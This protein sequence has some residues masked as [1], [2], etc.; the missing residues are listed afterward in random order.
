MGNRSGRGRRGKK[1]IFHK[2]R[3]P[4][5]RSLFSRIRSAFLRSIVY[6]VCFGDWFAKDLQ[7]LYAAILRLYK[8][9]CV[10][11]CVW[12]WR[13]MVS[14]AK[15]NV[16]WPGHKSNLQSRRSGTRASIA[17]EKRTVMVTARSLLRMF[18]SRLGN[19]KIRNLTEWKIQ[20]LFW[21]D[22]QFSYWQYFR[23][24]FLCAR[25]KL[26]R[27]KDCTECVCDMCKMCVKYSKYS[28]FCNRYVKGYFMKVR[29]FFITFSQKYDSA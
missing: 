29:V 2:R 10:C 11:V 25:G 28:D 26:K 20:F 17:R 3:N 19:Q 1:K 6:R 18:W 22:S 5:S 27:Y 14:A 23:N 21:K 15:A 12:Q 7:S 13:T 8:R 24:G 4:L 16:D 9:V